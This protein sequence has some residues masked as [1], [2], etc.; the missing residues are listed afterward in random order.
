MTA[1]DQT[2]VPVVVGAS[3][4]SAGLGLRDALF[5]EDADHAGVLDCLCGQGLAQAMVLST[6]DRVEVL[7]LT[8]DVMA[9]R[10]AVTTLFVERSGLDRASVEPQLYAHDGTDAVR[11]C[12]AVTAALESQVIGEPH[13]LG[14]VKAA[15]RLARLAGKLGTE[16]ESL[17]AAAYGAAKRVRSETAIAERPVSIAAAVAEL[18]RGVHG[19]LA[20]AEGILIGT[21]DMGGL[22][23][24][25]LL[26]AGLRRLTVAAPRASQAQALAGVLNCHVGDLAEAG[27]L[28]AGADIA[29]LALSRRHATIGSETVQAALRKRKRKPIFLVDAG[30]PGDVDPAVNRLDGAF[31]YDLADLERVALAGRAQRAAAATEA[32]AIVEDEVAAFARGQAGRQASPAIVALRAHFEAVRTQVLAEAPHDADKATRLLVARLLHEPSEGLRAL[33]A[34][35]E[36]DGWKRAER[37]LKRLFRIDD[38]ASSL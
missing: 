18:A 15:H 27:A 28:W 9:A 37:L 31:L 29:I 32:W 21:G 7:A 25:S 6:C 16:L 30:V 35:D 34:C 38:D 2:L 3:H 10:R 13:I 5:V 12:F 33:A 1:P 14:Q 26:A 24:E 20:R 17:L 11:H 23:A 36:A 8:R 22:I 4:K 19:D